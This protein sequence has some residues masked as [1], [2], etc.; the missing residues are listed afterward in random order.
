VN[1]SISFSLIGRLKA[2]LCPMNES[3]IMAIKRLRKIYDTMTWKLRKKN[4]DTPW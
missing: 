1:V 3:M 2:S 4:T